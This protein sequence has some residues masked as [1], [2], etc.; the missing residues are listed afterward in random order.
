MMKKGCDPPDTLTSMS[1][2]ARV[3]HHA[4]AV[5][6]PSCAA[7]ALLAAQ[8]VWSPGERLVFD[9]TSGAQGGHPGG[10][11]RPSPLEY[12]CGHNTDESGWRM[13][14]QTRPRW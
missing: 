1:S 6:A 9:R 14:P 5:F 10:K 11:R 12:T 7:S 3:L 4:T 13:H 2:G 8:R